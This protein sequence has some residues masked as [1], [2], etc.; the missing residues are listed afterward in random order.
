M[1]PC[2]KRWK[3]STY[4]ICRKKLSFLY[5]KNIHPT[6]ECAIF[7]QGR[8][9]SLFLDFSGVFR[10][11]AIPQSECTVIFYFFFKG[12]WYLVLAVVLFNGVNIWEKTA[13]LREKIREQGGSLWVFWHV[14]DRKYCSAVVVVSCGQFAFGHLLTM[15][16]WDG[17]DQWVDT[18]YFTWLHQH[19]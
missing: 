12:N 11:E 1:L 3:W 15:F 13:L 18:G 16:K 5:L 10:M 17:T 7:L 2:H 6:K 8:S 4:E 19:G 9:K 14:R